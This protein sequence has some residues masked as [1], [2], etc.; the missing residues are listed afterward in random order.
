[1]T[2][3]LPVVTKFSYRNLR[4]ACGSHTFPRRVKQGDQT[5]V[6]GVVHRWDK[7]CYFSG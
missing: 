4:C 3:Y 7:P 1:M 2:D 5:T 6:Y